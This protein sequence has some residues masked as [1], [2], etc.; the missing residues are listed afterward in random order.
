MGVKRPGR[1]VDQSLPFSVEFKNEWSHTFA[2]PLLLHG[3]HR[4]DFTFTRLHTV[5][6]IVIITLLVTVLLQ[7]VQ[8]SAKCDWT[9]LDWTGLDWTAHFVVWLS[10]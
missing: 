8:C 1:E 9:G 4:D 7:T 6:A 3:G 5:E 10:V 2:P